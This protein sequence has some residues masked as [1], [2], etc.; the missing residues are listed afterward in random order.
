MEPAGLIELLQFARGRARDINEIA[1]ARH[2]IVTNGLGAMVP[3]LTSIEQQKLPEKLVRELLMEIA[4]VLDAE[5]MRQ[6]LA[7]MQ[8]HALQEGRHVA[9][10]V[11]AL[12]VLTPH[13]DGAMRMHFCRWFKIPLVRRKC[14]RM[15]CG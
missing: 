5:E 3:L 15:P 13:A 8:R 6:A 4:A 10:R 9:S 14:G 11:I 2:R 12:K 7:A 1:Q